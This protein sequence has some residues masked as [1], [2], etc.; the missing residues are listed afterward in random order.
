[1]QSY[2]NYHI[3]TT[4]VSVQGGVWHGT[5]TVFESEQS[6]PREVYRIETA[7][8]FLFVTK[9]DAEEFVLMLCKAWID[10]SGRESP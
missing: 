8:D 2:K 10:N 9:K 3:R 7:N 6:D 5:G 1:M 4:A